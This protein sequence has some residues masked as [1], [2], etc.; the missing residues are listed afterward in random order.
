MMNFLDY[1]KISGKGIVF[2]QKLVEVLFR[3]FITTEDDDYCEFI[4]LMHDYYITIHKDYIHS[5]KE[6]ENS[7]YDKKRT[8]FMKNFKTNFESK[9][10]KMNQKRKSNR[11]TVNIHLQRSSKGRIKTIKLNK[12]KKPTPTKRIYKEYYKKSCNGGFDICRTA[13]LRGRSDFDY[14]LLHFIALSIWL[15]MSLYKKIDNRINFGDIAN[16]DIFTKF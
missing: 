9:L 13:E 7:L 5:E 11:E 10:K 8:L 2:L 3:S 12:K 6:K 15:N 14:N 4:N 16:Y 1:Q